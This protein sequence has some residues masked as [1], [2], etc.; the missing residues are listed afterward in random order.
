M[1][2]YPKEITDG[3]LSTGNTNVLVLEPKYTSDFQKLYA[4]YLV[5]DEDAPAHFDV[6][7]KLTSSLVDSQKHRSQSVNHHS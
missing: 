3:A 4:D 5:V 7:L 6:R 2:I 1:G